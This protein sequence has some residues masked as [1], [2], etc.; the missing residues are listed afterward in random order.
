MRNRDV[1][2][3]V[4]NIGSIRINLTINWQN[5][6]LNIGILDY[7]IYR[8]W[9]IIFSIIAEFLCRWGSKIICVCA[10]HLELFKA[11]R[12]I[13]HIVPTSNVNIVGYSCLQ[14]LCDSSRYF[15]IC[16]SYDYKYTIS[17]VICR[18]SLYF[19]MPGYSTYL[20]LQSTRACI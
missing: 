20:C 12:C 2:G 10:S 15:Y 16:S 19:T 1:Y 13:T 9:Q 7:S 11:T 6:C 14:Y 3:I 4:W 17:C 18:W 5:I 8:F